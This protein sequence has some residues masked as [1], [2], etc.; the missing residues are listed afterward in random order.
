MSIYN[1]LV[2]EARKK[3][4]ELL[5]QQDKEIQAIFE[6]AADDLANEIRRLEAS[7]QSARIPELL[8]A[9]LAENSAAIE[10]SLKLLFEKGL[11]LSVEAGM[12]QSRQTTLR[13]LNKAKIE[14]QPIERVYF[15]KHTA[16]VEAMQARVIKGL[17][18][19]DRIW[20]QSRVARQSMGA[21]IQEAL[22][23]GEHPYRVADMLQDYVRN[24][25]RT[26]VSQYPNM[27]ERLEG[28][29][30]MNMSYE[31]LRLARTEMAAAFGEGVRQAA[32]LNPSNVGMRW[33]TS[34]S[35]NTCDKCKDIASQDNGLGPGVYR[36]YEL[37]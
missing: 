31:S 20:G 5:L 18:L 9:R 17:T 35:G 29:L 30:P 10:E 11:N 16:A 28:N 33:S 32:E 3:L 4:I 1:A 13:I 19:S 25:A 14:W 36:M 26:V 15:R 21:I 7:G 22:V 6:K 8:D 12:H 24:G 2:L 27:V 37:P 23:A 34:N